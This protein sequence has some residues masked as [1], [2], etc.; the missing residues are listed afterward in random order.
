M[1]PATISRQQV[2]AF[3]EKQKEAIR[4]RFGDRPVDFRVVIEDGKPKVK[5]RPR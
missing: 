3:M 4:Q 1:D 2:E 5:V